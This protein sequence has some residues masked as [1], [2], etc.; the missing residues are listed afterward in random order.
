MPVWQQQQVVAPNSPELEN[1]GGGGCSG[2]RGVSPLSGQWSTLFQ[3]IKGLGPKLNVVE[4]M[5]QD[6][7]QNYDEYQA[8]MQ[9]ELFS[10]LGARGEMAPLLAAGTMT[11]QGIPILN[12]DPLARLIGWQNEVDICVNGLDVRALLDTGAQVTSVSDA[13]CMQLGLHVYKLKGIAMEGT[14]GI[15]IEYVGYTKVH[16]ALSECPKRLGSSPTI[17]IPAIVLKESEYQ[18]E[19]PVTLG[20]TALEG[21]LSQ[22]SLEEIQG[23]DEAWRLCHAAQVVADK[24]HAR[25]ASVVND[26]TCVAQRVLVLKWQVF[27]LG[28]S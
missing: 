18:K 21:L 19:V 10:L 12:P 26:L 17:S 2:A 27:P 13:L 14:G 23:L 11:K 4:E 28:Q 22:L 24:L 1:G 9:L 8:R 6:M 16:V 5:L 7:L 25:Q 15:H 20:V 3:D